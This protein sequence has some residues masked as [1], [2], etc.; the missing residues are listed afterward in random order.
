MASVQDDCLLV[1][2][3]LDHFGKADSLF[4]IILSKHRAK[5]GLSESL[6][7]LFPFSSKSQPHAREAARARVTQSL[8]LLA[9]SLEY[10]TTVL[11]Q[12]GGSVY[13][14]FEH[15]ILSWGG[16][17]LASLRSQATENRSLSGFFGTA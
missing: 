6:F 13:F 14:Q 5:N 9:T 16:V 1:R 12:R 10:G 3:S 7:V 17:L 8:L 11:Q 15:C 2:L 4:S